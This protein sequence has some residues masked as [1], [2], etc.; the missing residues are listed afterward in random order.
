MNLGLALSHLMRQLIQ[1]EVVGDPDSYDSSTHFLILSL[2][3][4]TSPQSTSWELQLGPFC[5]KHPLFFLT[6]TQVK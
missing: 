4:H 5:S 3:V 6:D 2:D 1:R